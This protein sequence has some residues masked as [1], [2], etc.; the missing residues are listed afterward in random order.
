LRA[1]FTLLE[2]M[3][4]ITLI[5]VLSSVVLPSLIHV[6]ERSR[7][8]AA[9]QTL[10]SIA[11]AM[12]RFHEETGLWPK[13]DETWN[14]VT[15]TAVAP[16]K[17]SA[18]DTALFI[19]PLSM[20]SLPICVKSGGPLATPCWGGPYLSKG[21]SLN[22]DW[23]LDPWGRKL[24]YAYLPKGHSAAPNGIIVVWST[25]PDGL[26]DTTDASLYARGLAAN[27]K[28]DDIIQVVGS[29]W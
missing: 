10:R 23:L 13:G 11:E 7:Q 4:A 12:R 24:R 21:S 15:D 22:E 9:V 8:T 3:L 18:T 6:V 28:S 27:S 14:P 5:V 20:A 1:G 25:G 2:V 26:D 16:T 19:R 17:V 29:A